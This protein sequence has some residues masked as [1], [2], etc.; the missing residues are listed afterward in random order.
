VELE[1]S[2]SVPVD[3]ATAWAV[4]RDIERVA[5]CMPGATLDSVEGEDFTGR[6]KVKVGAM[7]I[8]YKGDAS[9][10]EVDEEGHRAVIEARGRE[11]RGSG[12]ANATIRAQL[13][14]GDDGGTT[15]DVHTDLAVTG[16]PA[17][18]GRGI[19]A[20]VGGKLIGRFADCLATLLATEQA[21]AAPSAAAEATATEG[22][23]VV[24][25]TATEEQPAGATVAGDLA[26]GA[27]PSGA[28]TPAETVGGGTPTD[29]TLHPADAA[30]PTAGQLEGAGVPAAG[31]PRTPTTAQPQP[32]AVTDDVIDLFDV[33]GGPLLK[34]LAP[35]AVVA[36]VLLVVWWIRRD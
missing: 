34:R 24:A 23:T 21:E 5:P 27:E 15:V 8:T 26:V 13:T 3:V 28:G 2:F 16:K 35:V 20:D 10:V 29:G 17:Q 18:F 11:A 19:L 12:T 7:Q 25:G 31:A 1:H 33:A 30:A 32:R 6:V 22:D 14:A 9:F 4:L 36:L